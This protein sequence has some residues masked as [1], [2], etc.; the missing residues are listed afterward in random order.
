MTT[1]S[2]V[3]TSFLGTGWAFPPSFGPGGAEVA[4]VS[5][6]EDVHQSLQILLATSRG[7]RAMQEGF[8]ANLDTMMFEEVDPALLNRLTSLIYDAVLR[9]EPRIDLRAVEVTPS[10]AAGVLR[11]RIDYSIRGTN[12]RYNMVFP[13]YLNEAVVPVS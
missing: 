10:D 4:M 6:A 2:A 12:S 13:F 1:R 3:P 11:I 5:D 7:E 9:H 8:G